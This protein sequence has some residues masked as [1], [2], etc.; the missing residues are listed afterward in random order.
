MIIED[1]EQHGPL[2]LAARQDD[3]A[4]GHVEVE[5]PERMHVRHF[6]RP[7]LTRHEAFLEL[8]AT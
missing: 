2:P 6:E 7:P 4:S 5:V 1:A 3:A 8:M